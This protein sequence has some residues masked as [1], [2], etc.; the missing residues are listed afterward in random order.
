[1]ETRSQSFGGLPVAT[2][3]G[4]LVLVARGTFYEEQ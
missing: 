1:M 4:L 3:D 2:S